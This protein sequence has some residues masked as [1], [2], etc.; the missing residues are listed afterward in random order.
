MEY[1]NHSEQQKFSLSP[2]ALNL[3]LECPRCFWLERVKGHKRPQAP[4]PS[5]PSGIDEVIKAYFDTYRQKGELPPILDGQLEGQLVSQAEI[6]GWRQ[7]IG[8]D[9]LQKQGHFWGKLDDAL[10]LPDGS[11]A[12]LDYKTRGYPPRSQVIQAYQNQLDSYA[13]LLKELGEPV[14]S[15]GYLIYYYPQRNSGAELHAAIPFEVEIKAVS[16]DPERARKLL[17]QALD[18]LAAG[19]P[20]PDPGCAFCQWQRLG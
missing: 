20:E 19:E 18:L 7:G 8:F 10:R 6:D 4:F 3:F 16:I 11:V 14:G 9:I 13:L 5:L 12:P 15:L 2:S 1:Q 17:H